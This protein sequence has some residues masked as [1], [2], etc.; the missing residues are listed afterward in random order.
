[1]A[2]AGALAAS[3]QL[4]IQAIA[5]GRIERDLRPPPA[6]ASKPAPARPKT[7]GVA[8]AAEPEGVRFRLKEIQLEGN[9]TLA[10]SA[11]EDLWVDLLGQEVALD[12]VK[13]LARQI[14]RRYRGEGYILAQAVVPAQTIE[15][16]LVRIQ[17]VEGHV[18]R[19]EAGEGSSLDGLVGRYAE[20]IP[21]G[22]PLHIADLEQWLLLIND[23]PGVSAKSVFKPSPAAHGGA[24]LFLDVQ[25]QEYAGR[26]SLNNRAGPFYQD[27]AAD[28]TGYL[29]NR[30]EMDEQLF[31]RGAIAGDGAFGDRGGYRNLALGLDL[32]L[33][34]R[35]LV[36][37]LAADHTTSVPGDDLAGLGYEGASSS[38]SMR[39][40]YP[41]ERGRSR[42]LYWHTGVYVNESSLELEGAPITDD[43]VRALRT[44]LRLDWAGLGG[45]TL[46][47]LEFST[48]LKLFGASNPGELYLSRPE[49]DSQFLKAYFDL[50]HLRPLWQGGQL[51]IDLMAQ[52]ADRK[53][54]SGEELGF[55]GGRIG[56]GFDGSE[57]SADK[58]AGIGFEVSHA[59]P[60]DLQLFGFYD[61]ALSANKDGGK[62]TLSSAGLGIRFQYGEAISGQLE[63]AKPLT[64]SGLPA[65][66]RFDDD[67]RIFTNLSI[68]F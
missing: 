38:V 56:R 57:I 20:R 45:M 8:P 29:Y 65:G 30:F 17:V 10:R 64:R 63:L 47:Q 4:P 46:A 27:W 44:G 51:R 3:P 54:L 15:G 37:N 9:Q 55:G 18:V 12:Q 5:P 2:S 7:E 40:Q 25:R 61:T 34:Q 11:L 60:N 59:L 68:N 6:P 66:A 32:P 22:K 23:L 43:N 50:V 1:L 48:G 13:E 67:W 28:L 58:G 39:F 19:V 21:E 53:L 52:T 62:E 14:T 16:G 35:G 41:I 24:D 33:G 36:L 31:V 49:G 26:A 42:S